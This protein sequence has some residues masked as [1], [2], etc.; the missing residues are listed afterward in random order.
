MSAVDLPACLRGTDSVVATVTVAD[1]LQLTV[2][3][4]GLPA[5]P[6]PGRSP[7][8]LTEQ[9]GG[10]WSTKVASEDACGSAGSRTP[11][12]LK[13]TKATIV[14]AP[15]VAPGSVIVAWPLA[16]SVRAPLPALA[17]VI[18]VLQRAARVGH[19]V[20]VDGGRGDVDRH[21]AGRARVARRELE[22]GRD[23]VLTVSSKL[24]VA[25]VGIGV[26]EELVP[27]DAAGVV[28]RLADD[29]VVEGGL[30]LAAASRPWARRRCPRRPTRA[31]G[32]STTAARSR[33]RP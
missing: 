14:S 23:G 24:R 25:P 16:S 31:P 3:I 30:V 13:S 27:L 5:P 32:S 8:T 10:T 7:L 12:L 1:S 28:D 20:G 4:S 2:I 22:Q 15:A 6:P 19:A 33:S 29:G 18:V 26:V 21:A 17:P 11:S 9:V